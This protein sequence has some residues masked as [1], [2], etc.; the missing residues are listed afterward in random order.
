[1]PEYQN[2]GIRMKSKQDEK[3]RK[4]I[5][6]LWDDKRKSFNKKT[7]KEEKKKVET[8]QGARNIE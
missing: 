7:K 1:M 2:R 6:S 8:R 3:D 4:F 5:L